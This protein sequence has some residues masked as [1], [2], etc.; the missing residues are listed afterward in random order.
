MPR[1]IAASLFRLAQFHTQRRQCFG[2]FSTLQCNNPLNCLTRWRRQ[3]Y[4]P[5]TEWRHFHPK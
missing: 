2:K 1:F 3:L 4:L 5:C